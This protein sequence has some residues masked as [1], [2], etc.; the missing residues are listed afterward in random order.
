MVVWPPWARWEL[1][2]TDAAPPSVVAAA[3]DQPTTIIGLKFDDFNQK[4]KKTPRMKEREEELKWEKRKRNFFFFFLFKTAILF[5]FSMARWGNFWNACAD[6]ICTVF[7][8]RHFYMFWII[9]IWGKEF[10]FTHTYILRAR[11]R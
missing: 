4:E 8:V 1:K 10:T 9:Q 6:Q 2:A 11:E 5:L 3:E 7:A